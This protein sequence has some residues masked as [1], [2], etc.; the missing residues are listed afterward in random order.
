LNGIVIF[1]FI[2]ITVSFFPFLVA[3][4]DSEFTEYF[5]RLHGWGVSETA[6][7]CLI[8]KDLTPFVTDSN[9][10][11]EKFV[12]GLEFPVSIDFVGDDMLVLEKHSGK[13]IRI[14]DDG[15]LY[16]EP[17]LDVPVRFNYYSGLL[18]IATLSDRVF[19][20]YT[21]SESGDDVREGSS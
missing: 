14:S 9:Y 10:T 18:G 6:K 16:D 1:L 3:Y 12:S 13:V 2:I 21:E 15:V 19:L 5:C 11:I 17:I 20:Y 8:E 4:G 7:S